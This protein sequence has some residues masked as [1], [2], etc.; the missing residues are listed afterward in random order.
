MSVTFT[1]K[2]IKK[3]EMRQANEKFHKLEIIRKCGSTFYIGIA[4]VVLHYFGPWEN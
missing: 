2:S 4:M 1:A 3:N